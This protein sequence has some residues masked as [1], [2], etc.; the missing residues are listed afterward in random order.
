MK[1]AARDYR[2]PRCGW[3]QGTAIERGVRMRGQTYDRCRSCGSLW[4]R[5]TQ[6]W[7]RRLW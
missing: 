7:L 1:N 6:R 4:S 3:C 2:S 5:A